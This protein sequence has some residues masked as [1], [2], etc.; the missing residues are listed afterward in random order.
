M[1][2]SKQTFLRGGVR[3]VVRNSFGKFIRAMITG[4]PFKDS[5]K[6]KQHCYRL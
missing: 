6:K 3:G 5:K 1:D 2:V 4:I